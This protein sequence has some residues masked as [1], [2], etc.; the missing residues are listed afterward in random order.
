MGNER[1]S[2]VSTNEHGNVFLSAGHPTCSS[3]EPT[4]GPADVAIQGAAATMDIAPFA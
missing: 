4:R 1:V 3:E 2:D